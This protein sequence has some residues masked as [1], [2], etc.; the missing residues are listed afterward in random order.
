MQKLEKFSEGLKTCNICREKRKR[1]NEKH[2][3]ENANKFSQI[4][5]EV[6]TCEVCNYENKKYKKAQ[7]EKSQTHQYNLKKLEDPD[8]ESDVSKPDA[9]KL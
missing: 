4:K 9:I 2:K 6:I 1:F 7:H 8:F 5:E 3:Q